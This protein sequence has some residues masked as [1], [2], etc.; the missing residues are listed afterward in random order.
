MGSEKLFV[1]RQICFNPWAS[2]GFFPG[3]PYQGP[4]LDQLGALIG[5]VIFRTLQNGTATSIL[6]FQMKRKYCDL[7]CAVCSDKIA[8]SWGGY[9]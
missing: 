4:A 3:T 9:M 5:A 2:G 6:A 7:N 8:Y 1:C